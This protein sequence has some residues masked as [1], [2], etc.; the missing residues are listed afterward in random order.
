[1][2][3]SVSRPGLS[4]GEFRGFVIAMRILFRTICL[5]ILVGLIA[6]SVYAGEALTSPSEV[7]FYNG[8]IRLTGLWFV[9]VANK[10]V[11]AAVIVRGSGPSNRKS[12]WAH[13]VIDLLLEEQIAVL[14]PDK[15]GSDGSKGDWR[16]ADFDTLAGDVVA[17]VRYVQARGEVNSET[18]VTLVGLSQGGRVAPV[19][20]S[21]SEEIGF[22]IDLSGSATPFV[23]QVSWEMYHTFRDAGLKGQQLQEALVLQVMAEKFV[24]GDVTWEAYRDAL[25]VALQSSWA[26]VAEGFPS[27]RGA[28]QWDFFRGVADFDPV[29]CWRQVKQ[30][31]L[32]VYGE[33]DRN[34]PAV[35]SVYRLVRGFMESSHPD[36]TVRT[37]EGT[38]HSIGDPANT[39]SHQ[40][41]LHPALVDLMRQWVRTRI[42]NN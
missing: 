20:A 1:M 18:G 16:T 39:T 15:R 2:R 30:P 27:E 33:S 11:S 32:I 3:L 19:A 28:W 34:A 24:K 40:M 13:A 35:R 7:T 4:T 41:S 22:V 10:P 42:S 12:L 6:R 25:D 31:V 23:E 26:K 5:A 17:A 37:I 38:G 14:L 29:P 36:W 8:D 9:P 21:R